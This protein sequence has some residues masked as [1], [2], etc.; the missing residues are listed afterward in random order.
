M[1]QRVAFTLLLPLGSPVLKPN[2]ERKYIVQYFESNYINQR[3]LI[4]NFLGLICLNFIFI[5]FQ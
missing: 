4:S 2:L 1:Q 3:H 5:V